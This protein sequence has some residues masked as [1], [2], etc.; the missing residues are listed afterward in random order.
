MFIEDEAGVLAEPIKQQIASTGTT[1][2]VKVLVSTKYSRAE[3]DAKV[4]QM[5]NSANTLAIGVDPVHRY[6][7][8]H[9]GT[10]TKIGA[11][12]Y[13]EVATAGNGEFKQG[14]WGPGIKAIVDSANA[15]AVAHAAAPTAVIIQQPK[16]VVEQPMP[17]WP[18]F[19][20]IGGLALLFLLLWRWNRKNQEKFDK[21]IDNLQRE[22]AEFASNN[23]KS[24]DKPATPKPTPPSHA[25]ANYAKAR[26]A[27]PPPERYTAPSRRWAP[28]PPVQV[29][30]EVPPAPVVI[31]RGSND[32][33]TGMLV[34]DALSSRREEHHHHHHD[35]DR[36]SRSDSGSSGGG[37]SWGGGSDSGSSGGDFGGGGGGFD[38]GS[39]GG[40]F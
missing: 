7:F 3:L 30:R 22:T 4:G 37:F 35:D 20:G 11:T 33:L 10:G 2:D 28:P 15:H 23:I 27:E 6:T 14:N 16:T 13:R 12:D 39:S 25:N 32:F 24:W 26:A 21:T 36:S 17:L 9:F 19:V 29:V 5:V 34:G 1:L 18:F 40:D 31:D 38:G 8:T